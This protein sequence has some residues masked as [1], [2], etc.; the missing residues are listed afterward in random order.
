MDTQFLCTSYDC[1]VIGGSLFRFVP[2]E[3]LKTMPDQV[4]K[5]SLER[6]THFKVI[7]NVS[8]SPE[9]THIYYFAFTLL[10]V[11]NVK[12]QHSNHLGHP[13]RSQTISQAT[14]FMLQNVQCTKILILMLKLMAYI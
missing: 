9:V 13:V 8:A 10:K 3:Q 12:L 7:S 4:V 14:L 2:F 11:I 5:Y 6:S 1:E